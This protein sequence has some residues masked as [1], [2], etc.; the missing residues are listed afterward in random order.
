MSCSNFGFGLKST[1]LMTNVF[2]SIVNV[3]VKSLKFVGLNEGISKCGFDRDGAWALTCISCKDVSTHT[4]S[5]HNKMT[6]QMVNA[7]A[8]L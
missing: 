7:A 3:S 1:L 8:L 5:R 4:L 2:V 6:K